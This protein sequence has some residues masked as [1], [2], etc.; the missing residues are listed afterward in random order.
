VVHFEVVQRLHAPVDAVE[1]ALVDP[2]FL[3]ALAKLPKLGRPVLI[4]QRPMGDRF[5]QRVRYDFAGE[6]SS[7][8]KAFIDPSRLSWVEES[9]QDRRTHLTDIA[10]VPDYY[11][12]IFECFGI[13]R[14]EV[15]RADGLTVRTAAG[16]VNVR[17]PL[18]GGKAEAAIISGLREHADLEAE[19]LDKWVSTE[20]DRRSVG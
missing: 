2:Q 20:P 12:S 1:A 5:F 8:V 17:V 4:E 14:L 10:I 15:D 6:L 16:E 13:I 9:T 18:V 7:T 19:M 11:N 3:E